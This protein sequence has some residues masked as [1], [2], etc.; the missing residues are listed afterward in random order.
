MQQNGPKADKIKI[1]IIAGYNSLVQ[2]LNFPKKNILLAYF[3][4]CQ[5]ND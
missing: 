5:I 2:A 1:L 4:V 3:K